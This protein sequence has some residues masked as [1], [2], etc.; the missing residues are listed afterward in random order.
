MVNCIMKR[1]YYSSSISKFLSASPESILGAI[2]N[3]NAFDVTPFQRDAWIEQ[4]KILKRALA[5]HSGQIYLEFS[6]P[7]MGKRIDALV[8][9]GPVIFVIEFK[10]GESKF[11][12]ADIDQV[13]DY[14]LDLHNFHEGSHTAIIAPILVA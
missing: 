11:L 14:A 3:K 1:A 8:I 10:I 7:R 12:Q 9:I 13:T 4:T 6:I 2:T 5:G